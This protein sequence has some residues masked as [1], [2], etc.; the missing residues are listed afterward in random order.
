MI[1]DF[2]IGS[3]PV[4]LAVGFYWYATSYTDEGGRG[5]GTL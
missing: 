1:A 5:G 4:L 3:L 2:L